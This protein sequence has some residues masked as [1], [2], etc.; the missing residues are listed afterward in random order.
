MEKQTDGL[1]AELENVIV[2]RKEPDYMFVVDKNRESVLT[3][4]LSAINENY[5]KMMRNNDE[6]F[7][8]LTGSR[9]FLDYRSYT[10]SRKT[11]QKLILVHF[12]DRILNQK[13]EEIGMRVRVQ[14]KFATLPF[15]LEA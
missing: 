12:S 4:Q 3:D 7:G 15:V 11:D 13:A 14:N 1:K 9:K 6:R 10:Y 5:V 8:L 2:L